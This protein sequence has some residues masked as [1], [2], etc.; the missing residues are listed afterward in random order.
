MGGRSDPTGGAAALHPLEQIRAI[1]PGTFG[2]NLDRS[3]AQVARRSSQAQRPGLVPDPP[4]QAHPLHMPDH[5][6]RDPG[7]IGPPNRVAVC[8]AGVAGHGRRA[9]AGRRRG[10]GWQTGQEKLDLFMKASRRTGV[11]QRGQG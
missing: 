3:V 7:S 9:V 8:L 6:D 11:P 10:L 4:P 5:P 2:D 1:R